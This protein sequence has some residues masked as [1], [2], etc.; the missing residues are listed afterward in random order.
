MLTTLLALLALAVMVW[1]LFFS[2][3]EH[4]VK[5]AP[6]NNIPTDSQQV[7]RSANQ[8][9]QLLW[10]TM[11][12]KSS[13]D[14][15]IQAIGLHRFAAFTTESSS[16]TSFALVLANGQGNGVVIS[17]LHSRAGTRIYAKPLRVWG[18]EEHNLSAEEHLAI[19]NAQAS[20]AGETATQNA[21]F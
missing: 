21:L 5:S 2:A 12:M 1:M 8:V 18:V 3:A 6:H 15:S 11:E 13:L 16:E 19:Q 20:L 9:A 4:N 7:E 14:R 17:S 10:S